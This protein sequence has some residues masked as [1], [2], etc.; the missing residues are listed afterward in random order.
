MAYQVSQLHSYMDVIKSADFSSI[1]A[2]F[3]GSSPGSHQGSA[4]SHFGHMAARSVFRKHDVK[5]SW[6]LIIQCSSIGSLGQTPTT[7]CSSEL[8]QSL[9][10]AKDVQVIYPSKKNVMDSLDGLLGTVHILRKHLYSTKLNLTSKFFTK[11]GFFCQNKRIS[12]STLHFDK[13]F[14][15]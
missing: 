3:I 5:V 2:F 6:P 13:I 14:M 12:F 10:S 7:W 1:N 11:T 9:G 4:L 15:L 8:K